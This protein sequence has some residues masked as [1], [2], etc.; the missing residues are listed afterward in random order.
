MA[1]ARRRHQ[2]HVE[3]PLNLLTDLAFNLVI[4][5]VVCAS[6]EPEKGRPQQMPSASQEKS[7]EQAKGQNIEVALT[8]TTVSVNGTDVPLV[9]LN[10]KLKPLLAGKSRTED[11]IV[12]VRSTKDTPY[13]HWIKASAAVEQA[14]GVIALQLEEEKE[15][16]VK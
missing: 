7:A 3:P 4:F 2:N 10:A 9:D 13:R 1:F 5:F 15:V 14:G 11:R 8:R 6:T 16:T 12:V